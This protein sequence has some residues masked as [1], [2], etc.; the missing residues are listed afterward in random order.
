MANTLRGFPINAEYLL[1]IEDIFYLRSYIGECHITLL[2]TAENR[3]SPYNSCP[4]PLIS[5][6]PL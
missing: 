4:L 3:K 2:L 5:V 1:D 6:T